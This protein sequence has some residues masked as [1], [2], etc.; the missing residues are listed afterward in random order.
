MTAHR[1]FGAERGI[2]EGLT[3]NAYA[4]PTKDAELRTLPALTVLEGIER[5]LA[6]AREHTELTFEVTRIG[7]GLAGFQDGQIAPA[8]INAPSNCILPYRWQILLRKT[9]TPRVIVAGSRDFTNYRLLRA[10]LDYFT[11]GFTVQPAIVSGCARGADALGEQYAKRRSLEIVRFPAEWDCFGKSAGMLRNAR[12]AWA[13]SHLVAFW[14]GAS[15]GTC[16][17]IETAKA[18]G[19]AVRVVDFNTSTTGEFH[20]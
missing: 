15:P 3:G 16:N 12:M 11:G 14:D 5:F 4:L 10:K 17:M 9:E 6:F 18:E 13:S 8:F 7:C 2:G 20:V 1:F 19:L